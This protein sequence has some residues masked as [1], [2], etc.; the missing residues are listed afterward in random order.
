M[1]TK[2]DETPALSQV[3][4]APRSCCR[5]LLHSCLGVVTLVCS[6]QL[7]PTFLSYWGTS[8]GRGRTCATPVPAPVVFATRN[9]FCTGTRILAKCI[10]HALQTLIVICA[11]RDTMDPASKVL[12]T[13][14]IAKLRIKHL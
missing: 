5:G 7:P 13:V 6:V 4:M 11:I 14:L 1:G 8:W 3:H 10:A 12:P 2:L 9:V